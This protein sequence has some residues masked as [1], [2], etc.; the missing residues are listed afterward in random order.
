MAADKAPDLDRLIFDQVR[1][2]IETYREEV[3]KEAERYIKALEAVQAAELPKKSDDK[4]AHRV[5]SLKKLMQAFRTYTYGPK[6]VTTTDVLNA[7]RAVAKALVEGDVDDQ[8][9]AVGHF[10][11]LNGTLREIDDLRRAVGFYEHDLINF[12]DRLR[13]IIDAVAKDLA[14]FAPK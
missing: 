7:F 8:H 1:L 5:Y 11:N 12:R 14:Q 10:M 2:D 9:D 4:I 6:T 13:T 3:W